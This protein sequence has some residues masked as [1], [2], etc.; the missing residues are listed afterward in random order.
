MT[1]VNITST[2]ETV[3]EEIWKFVFNL[4]GQ[5]ISTLSAKFQKEMSYNENQFF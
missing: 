5:Y 3:D 4:G 1:L 2:Y